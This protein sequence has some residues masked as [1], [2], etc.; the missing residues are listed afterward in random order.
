M[1]LVPGLDSDSGRG[2]KAKPVHDK[3]RLEMIIGMPIEILDG[4]SSGL[5]SNATR[6]HLKRDLQ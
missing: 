4:Q 6:N 3:M 5:F 1:S 2:R